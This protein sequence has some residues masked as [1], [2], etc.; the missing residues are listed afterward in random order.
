[1]GAWEGQT[2]AQLWEMVREGTE[3][4]GIVSLVIFSNEGQWCPALV[5]TCLKVGVWVC[6]GERASCLPD[7]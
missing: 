1:M 4:G 5:S 6:G 3:V 7:S 2:Q